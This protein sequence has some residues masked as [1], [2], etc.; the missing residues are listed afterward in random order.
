M[1][2]EKKYVSFKEMKKHLTSNKADTLTFAVD[3]LLLKA[4]SLQDLIDKIAEL[5]KVKFSESNDFKTAAIIKKHIRYRQ[6]HN[7]VLFTV[8]KKNQIR[9]TNVDYESE[10]AQERLSF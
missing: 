6:T 4:N 3:Q 2:L 5:K 8:N 1:R 10:T 7:R 9:M